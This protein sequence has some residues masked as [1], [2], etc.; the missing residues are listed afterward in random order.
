MLGKGNGTFSESSSVNVS[1]SPSAVADLNGDNLYDLLSFQG[2]VAVSL[3]TSPIVHTL[4]VTFTGD[5]SGSISSNPAG[6]NCSSSGGTCSIGQISPGAVYT[7]AATPTGNSLFAGWSGACTGTDPNACNVTM[8][9]NESVTAKFSL[10]PDFTLSP[11]AQ[12]LV[13]KH[14]GQV[15]ETLMIGAQGGFSRGIQ[16]SCNVTGRA[17]LPTCSLSP[18]TIPPGANSPTSMLTVNASGLSA[19]LVPQS[20]ER[21]GGLYTTWLPWADGMHAHRWFR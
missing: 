8:N 14:G 7:L 21:A 5:G 3:N 10:A 18:A 12:N 15:N 11:T 20:L 13:V 2:G 6:V 19:A 1:F 17:P 16:L 9:S 4:T